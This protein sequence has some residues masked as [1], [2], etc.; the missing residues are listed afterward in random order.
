MSDFYYLQAAFQS[1]DPWA[2]EN[3]HKQI[4]RYQGWM[5]LSESAA[6]EV[7]PKFVEAQ[8]VACARGFNLARWS[9]ISMDRDDF[10]DFGIKK[11]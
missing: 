8:S 9:T 5:L 4:G 7:G 11:D 2:K 3:V 1:Y 10:T 6:E